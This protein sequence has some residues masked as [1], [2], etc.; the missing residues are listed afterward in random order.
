[1]TEINEIISQ[2]LGV[3]SPIEQNESLNLARI[4]YN[5]PF[6]Q[7]IFRAQEIHRQHFDPDAIQMSRL[8]S[9]KTGGC[10]E[11]CGYCSQSAHYPTGLKASKLME[12]ERVLAEAR[13]AQEGGATRYCM[14][15]AWRSPKE[16]DMDMLVA[17]V[18][19][20]KAMG[21][22]TCMTLGM[23]T[24]EQSARLSDAGLDYYNHNI[25]TSERFYPEIITTRTFE[26]RLETLANVR[27]AGI[28]VCAGGIL[29]MGET[30]DDRISMLV[31]LAS[32]PTPPESVPINMLIPIPGSRL[33]NAA[34][35]DPFDF[36][37]TIALA[38]ILMPTSY[39]RLSAGRTDMSDETQALC[40]LAGANSI[41]VGD[42]LLTADN[43]GE[44]HDS[45]LFRRLGLKPM[46]L[47]Q[48][49]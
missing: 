30:V 28:K 27:D 17:M 11:D 31:T 9:I 20:V 44:D 6:I 40:F 5:L 21:M 1:M 22:E 33:A 10:A 42:T 38:R 41:F 8:L 12:V 32:L 36:I 7:L 23:L 2:K 13:K 14:G 34:P 43:P 37:R 19:G 16:R 24:P 4:I 49:R 18:E 25:D 47:E 26:D 48:M 39:V 3:D 15:A 46:T 45:A 29:G 35:I